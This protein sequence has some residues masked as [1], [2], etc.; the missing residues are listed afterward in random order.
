MKFSELENIRICS[1]LVAYRI[2]VD[3]GYSQENA[4][5]KVTLEYKLNPI[6][7][8]RMLYLYRAV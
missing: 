4:K 6:Q 1:A 2:L 5:E 8:K 7:L 3:A